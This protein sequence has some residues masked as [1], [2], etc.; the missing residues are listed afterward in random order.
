MWGQFFFFEICVFNYCRALQKT[1]TNYS[2]ILQYVGTKKATFEICV[3]NY[4]RAFVFI[5]LLNI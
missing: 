2:V 3:F 5:A 4:C 1:K